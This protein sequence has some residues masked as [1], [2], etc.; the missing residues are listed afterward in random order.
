MLIIKK[1][2]LGLS[3]IVLITILVYAHFS[4]TGF[5]EIAKTDARLTSANL[6]QNQFFQSGYINEQGQFL[7]EPRYDWAEPFSDGVAYVEFRED[8][9]PRR[10]FINRA[11]ELI[12]SLLPRDETDIWFER[13]LIINHGYIFAEERLPLRQEFGGKIGYIDTAGE[14]VIEPQFDSADD[15]HEGLAIVNW[16]ESEDQGEFQKRYIDP[17]GNVKLNLNDL[18]YDAGSSFDQGAAIV[19]SGRRF[20]F[21]DKNGNLLLE[22]I[23][24]AI[25]HWNDEEWPLTREFVSGRLPVKVGEP[26]EDSSYFVKPEW[27]GKWGYA[28]INGGFGIEPQ[29]DCAGDFSE[30]RAAVIP[31]SSNSMNESAPILIDTDGNR[32]ELDKT[33]PRPV[34]RCYSLEFKEGLAEVESTDHHYG[35][36]NKEGQWAIPPIFYTARGFSQGLAPAQS[37]KT[38]LWGYINHQGDFVIPPQYHDAKEFDELGRAIVGYAASSQYLHHHRYGVVNLQGENIVPAKYESIYLEIGIGNPIPYMEGFFAKENE[39]NGGDY[40]YYV[41]NLGEQG[42]ACIQTIAGFTGSERIPF[43]EGLLPVIVDINAPRGQCISNENQTSDRAKKSW[44]R[45]N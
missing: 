24:S 8:K 41:S 4:N 37:M 29:F 39:R 31:V 17:D 6:S 22:P 12:I 14:F 43:S 10:G 9:K 38:K 11:G 5:Q 35:Y 7:I 32:I 36:I 44:L 18:G 23:L 2:T 30:G 45:S 28:D 1:W 42:M 20:G 13:E 21:I 40:N 26:Q 19:R 3:A 34:L 16:R 25:A 15:F 33:E 27:V